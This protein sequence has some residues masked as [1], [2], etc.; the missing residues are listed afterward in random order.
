MNN[1]VIIGAG[2]CGSALLKKLHDDKEINILGIVE[3]NQ[4][5]QGIK[6]AKEYNV[7]IAN[8]FTK[9]L[10]NN[11]VDTIFNVTG[12][13]D[14][15]ESIKE[16][17][18]KNA[19]IIGYDGSKL[20][21]K[22]ID[23]REEVIAE[24]EKHSV[25]LERINEKLKKM[26]KLKTDFL[27]MVS[28]ELR[29][30]LTS[31]KAFA[32]ILL[33]NPDED[34]ETRQEFIGIINNESDRL[35]RLIND[36]LDLSKIESGKIEWRIRRIAIE[37]LAKQV[38]SSFQGIANE[39][40]IKI[41]IE[42]TDDL[43]RVYIDE[44][45]IIQVMNNLI[46]NA[47]KFTPSGGQV[48]ITTKIT[49]DPIYG[50]MVSVS[51]TGIGINKEDLYLVFDKFKQVWTSSD[52]L[53][54]KPEGT[55]LGL[56][57]SKN[58]IERYEGKIWAESELGKGSTFSFIIPTSKPVKIKDEK[59]IILTKEKREKKLILVVDDEPN[60]RKFLNYHL[61][62]RGYDVVD[63][64]NAEEAVERTRQY[65]PDLITLDVIMP[66]IGGF[67]VVSILKNDPA[68]KNIPIL[69]IS[70]IDEKKRGYCLGANAYINKPI[71]KE[72]L[73]MKIESLLTKEKEKKVLIADDDHTIVK[74]IKYT[75]DRK[76]YN[77]IEAFNGEEA[78]EKVALEAPDLVILD[79]I[80]PK[81]NGYEVIQKMKNIPETA[82]IP[83]I[84][85]TAYNIKD[86]RVRA[87]SLG[88]VDYFNKGEEM[89]L[90]YK[91]IEEILHVDS[92]GKEEDINS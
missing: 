55:G 65:K 77:T 27:S 31:I 14:V 3:I 7:P 84:I 49:K 34:L 32:E 59:E 23:E 5:A 76:N 78:I 35:T 47:L 21:V 71:D 45:S 75:L 48:K 30:P 39:K 19:E 73:V 80:M 83:I 63:A 44:D 46:S 41:K 92:Y 12:S 62:M 68:T 9:L 13:R 38:A 85:L 64:Y 1:I 16:K 37:S 89:D 6:L 69:M 40:N 26:D 18:P 25:E 67:D 2:R 33:S 22:L 20:I 54:D 82:N 52:K 43:P 36:I 24:K 91:E 56:A 70:I 17:K 8:D 81:M 88:A 50:V 28:H 90:L 86:G 4:D 10:E 66:G 58:I 57:I 51:D 60:A 79:I 72:E 61:T 42:D 11:N 74:A 15:E 29:T 53:I 87:L